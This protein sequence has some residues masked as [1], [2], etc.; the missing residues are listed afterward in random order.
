M[1][2][3]SQYDNDVVHQAFLLQA[4]I[5]RRGQEGID[6]TG[7]AMAYWESNAADTVQDHV[8]RRLRKKGF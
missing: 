5:K 4:K 2:N 6:Y 1:A 7:A 8:M 3:L